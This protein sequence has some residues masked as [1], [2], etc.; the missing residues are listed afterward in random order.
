MNEDGKEIHFLTQKLPSALCDLMYLKPYGCCNLKLQIAQTEQSKM[1]AVLFGACFEDTKVIAIKGCFTS[2]IVVACKGLRRD[3]L[4]QSGMIP[5]LKKCFSLDVQSF[6]DALQQLKDS[7]AVSLERIDHLERQTQIASDE[8]WAEDF[9]CTLI[10]ARTYIQAA[11][12]GRVSPAPEYLSP[13]LADMMNKRVFSKVTHQQRLQNLE[14]IRALMKSDMGGQL[15]PL[16]RVV[17]HPDLHTWRV[18]PQKTHERGETG[19][20]EHR[21]REHWNWDIPSPASTAQ[22]FGFVYPPSPFTTARRVL[23]I[24]YR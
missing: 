22:E 12:E 14:M 9:R 13:E 11:L 6:K 17:F 4:Y 1:L 23:S 16:F 24:P 15:L 8:L 2:R 10:L 5:A 18:T 19:Q 21:K 3:I 20:S 7:K